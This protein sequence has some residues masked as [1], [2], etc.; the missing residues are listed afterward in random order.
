MNILF[1]PFNNKG[2]RYIDISKSILEE[3]GNAL[4]DFENLDDTSLKKQD[5][6]FLNWYES[7]P[8]R[9]IGIRELRIIKKL[10]TLDRFIR[11]NVRIVTVFHNRIP[12]DLCGLA[13]I[14][15]RYLQKCL[16][17]YADK[18][19]ILSKDSARYL[20]EY[21]TQAE[22]LRKS[23]YIPHPNYIGVYSKTLDSAP[24]LEKHNAMKILFAGA[25]RKY[26]NID[27]IIEM[28]RRTQDLNIEYTIAGQ[29]ISDRYRKRIELAAASVDNLRLD[30]R[31]IE[32]SR[33]EQLVRS[34][35]IMIAPYDITSS[36][37]SGTVFLAFSNGRSVICPSISSIKEFREDLIYSYF[38]KDSKDHLNKLEQ[39]VRKAYSDYTGNRSGFEEKGRKLFNEVKEKNSRDIL[40]KLYRK[41]LDEM[42]IQG[43]CSKM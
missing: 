8:S 36:M 41:L 2:N 43:N 22:I 5:I 18:I 29:C 23:V 39:M 24:E 27:L 30:L 15:T 20:G 13:K 28:A 4:Y 37:N 6:V 11:N 12:H 17:Q 14:E 32:D 9:Y 42:N 38:Y 40:R 25:V 26:K 21:I 16:L 1:Y 31:F 34:H 19:I 35:D 33:L 3:C 10:M 7:C